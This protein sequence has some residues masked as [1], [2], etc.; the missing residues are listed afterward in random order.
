MSLDVSLYAAEQC[1]NCG[2]SLTSGEC[3]Y[4]ANITHNLGRMASEAGCYDACWRPDEHGITTAAQVAEKLRP[5]IALM[6]ADPDRFKAHDSPNGWGLYVNFL[7]WL[8][9]Y[10]AACEANPTARVEVSR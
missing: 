2:H 10:L 9:R 7:P 1:P 3:V 6:K 5:A 4:S 8:E